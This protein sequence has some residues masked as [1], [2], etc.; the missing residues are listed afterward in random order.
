MKTVS[1][2]AFA[3]ACVFGFF[4]LLTFDLFMEAFVFEWL[5]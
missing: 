3:L 1:L 4:G 2:F 5:T